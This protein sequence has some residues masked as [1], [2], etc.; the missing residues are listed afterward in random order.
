MTIMTIFKKNILLFTVLLFCKQM[1]AQTYDWAWAQRFGDNNN[2]SGNSLALDANG[3]I[4]LCGT[5]ASPSISF[6]NISLTNSNIAGGVKDAFVAKFSNNGTPVWAFKIGGSGNDVANSIDVD[7]QG[8]CYVIGNFQ[9]TSINIGGNT[10]TNPGAS[11]NLYVAKISPAGVYNWSIRGNG[12]GNSGMSIAVDSLG[13]SFITG[14]FSNQFQ[15]GSLALGG[16]SE[17]DG[18][19]G[20]LNNSGTPVWL[21]KFGGISGADYGRSVCTD[22]N[23]NSFVTGYFKCDYLNIGSLSIPNSDL[24]SGSLDM[25]LAKFD[26]SG[27]ALWAIPGGET[28]AS[29]YGMNVHCDA[30]GNVYATGYFYSDNLTF[31]STNLPNIGNNTT[32]VFVVKY[33]SAGSLQWARSAGSTG[34]DFGMAVSTD[35]AGNVYLIGAYENQSITIGTVNLPNSGLADIFVAQYDPSGNVVWAKKAAGN[36]YDWGADIAVDNNGSCYAT[37]NISGNANFGTINTQG[38]FGTEVFLAN[39]S[40]VSNQMESAAGKEFNIFPNP[41]DENINLIFEE[42]QINSTLRLMDVHGK[43]IMETKLSGKQVTLENGYLDPGVYY[44]QILEG[45]KMLSVKKL[46]VR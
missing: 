42:E 28:N 9:S 1:N 22:G 4:Y 39:L 8:N 2:E 46:M 24:N 21:K 12:T 5:F 35:A 18:F 20:K 16:L 6:G 31:Q 40:V 37:G 10:F 25:F 41:S 19:V 45:G 43:K 38:G 32:D 30:N 27:N 23:G 14:D 34:N 36:G 26:S 44:V 29:D 11:T 7:A 33:S 17:G 13:N 15:L 3:N